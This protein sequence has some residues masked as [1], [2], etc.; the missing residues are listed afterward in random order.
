MVRTNRYWSE[1]ANQIRGTVGAIEGEMRVE[2]A[3]T[4]SSLR[5]KWNHAKEEHLGTKE[6]GW[7]ATLNISKRLLCYKITCMYTIV[8]PP[9]SKQPAALNSL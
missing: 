4:R 2:V 3:L 5:R 8:H 9:T 6:K 7:I 1:E